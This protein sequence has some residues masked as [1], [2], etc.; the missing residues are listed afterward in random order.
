MNAC[1]LL[2]TYRVYLNSGMEGAQLLGTGRTQTM[3]S[4]LFDQ[5]IAIKQTNYRHNKP[6]QNKQTL[7]NI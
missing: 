3:S 2:N 4:R 6:M 1:L 5:P 7:K